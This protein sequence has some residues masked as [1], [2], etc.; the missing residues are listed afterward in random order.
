MFPVTLYDGF[1]EN[2]DEIREFAL[3]LDYGKQTGNFPGERTLPLEYIDFEFSSQFFLRIL[4]LFYDL[5]KE[6][7]GFKL[8]SYF[9]KIYPYSEEINDPLNFGWYH[10]DDD[11][12]LAAG[13]VYLNPIPNPNAGTVFG[14][15][16]GG[17]NPESHP[18]YS[19][20]DDL[21]GNNNLEGIDVDLYRKSVIKHNSLFETTVEVKNQYNR[22]IF[23]D[24]RI[25]HRENNFFCN[26]DE[27]RLTHVFF[28]KYFE[29]D[30]KPLNRMFNNEI[31]TPR[32]S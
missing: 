15:E 18:D 3:S 7:I 23:Y 2:P 6:K 19:I 28:L 32:L 22:L 21:Y 31:Q 12:N 8:E 14:I 25:P 24:S 13:I 5:D 27:P 4:S 10:S 11:H 26:Y 16:T 17:F 9:Q 20:R 29:C 1:Y 30:T